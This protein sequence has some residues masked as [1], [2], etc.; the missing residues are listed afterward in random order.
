MEISIGQQAESVKT[1]SADLVHEFAELV[2]DRNPIHLN[3]EYAS[4]TLFKEPIA[5]GM[6]VASQ[7]SELIASRLPGPGS[8]YLEQNLRFLKPVYYGDTIKCTVEVLDIEIKGNVV[9]KT[10]CENQNGI[11][12][13]SGTAKVKLLK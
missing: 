2:G 12:V 4:N 5:H 10:D 13:I 1:Y 9:L 7:I 8:I 11:A 6:L 3:A